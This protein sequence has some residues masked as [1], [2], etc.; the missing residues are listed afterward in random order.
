MGSTLQVAGEFGLY[1]L[2]DIGTYLKYYSENLTALQQLVSS[3][4]T[5]INVYSVIAVNATQVVGVKFDLTMEFVNWFVSSDA[6]EL[7]GSYGQADYGQSLFIPAVS[8]LQ[9]QEPLNVFNWIQTSAFFE[10]NGTLYEC[11]PQWRLGVSETVVP[12]TL[13]GMNHYVREDDD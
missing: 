5:L 8:I 9:T 13:L 7:I 6:Q 12:S 3:D 4:S 10:F 11:P 2:S 1:V